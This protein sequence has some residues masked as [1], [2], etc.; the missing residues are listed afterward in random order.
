V[1][2]LPSPVHSFE[3]KKFPRQNEAML[4]NKSMIFILAS[5]Y[6]LASWGSSTIPFN[7]KI[8]DYS[9]QA[10]GTFSKENHFM[11]KIS[12]PKKDLGYIWALSITSPT[13]LAKNFTANL[14][15]NV[16]SI[17]LN[18]GDPELSIVDYQNL[19]FPSLK[20]LVENEDDRVLNNVFNDLGE[21][22]RTDLWRLSIAS[23]SVQQ[24]DPV[25]DV[26]LS[27]ILRFYE[28]YSNSLARDIFEE[29]KVSGKFSSDKIKILSMTMG[30]STVS[31]IKD[32]K[33]RLKDEKDL[34]DF[35]T[36]LLSYS[37]ENSILKYLN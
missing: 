4:L 10:E 7:I 17:S 5:L 13:L 8:N 11:V 6:S 18:Y 27:Q 24:L 12:V 14:S 36:K 37:E 35:V 15:Q 25:E 31:E 28:T 1:N 22:L 23:F 32:M 3:R 16:V 9:F 30:L 29:A 21:V 26:F 33:I 2:Y 34:L 20:L 19:E